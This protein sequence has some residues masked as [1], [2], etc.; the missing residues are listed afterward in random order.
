ML[1]L[2]ELV[3]F[4]TY[5]ELGTL[6]KAAESLH[7]SQPT[8]TRTMQ[9]V[10]ESF[11]VTLFSRSKNKIEL[12]QT[13]EKALALCRRLLQEADNTV[14]QVRLY[15]KSLRTITVESCA[16]APLWSLL[17]SLSAANPGLT[18]T[19]ELK[20]FD[21]ILQHLTEGACDLG[22]VTSDTAVPEHFV[23]MPFLRESLSVCV[24]YDHQLAFYDSL[25]F[26]EMN[27][28]NFLLY[29]EIGFWDG[30]CREKMP[31]SKFL[32]QTDA[33]TFQELI[34]QSKLPCFCTNLSSDGEF[35]T[36]RKIIPITDPQANITY[37]MVFREGDKEFSIPVQKFP[38]N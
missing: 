17:P 1:N 4:V 15:D 22:I 7:I 38:M 3:Q 23:S 20:G 19:S 9:R 32:V 5:G 35:L 2:E 6:T 21:A 8:I 36:D 27:G 10:E 24:P 29:S 31:A 37:H 30:M 34:R 18:I 13:G 33:F 28:Y 16:P 26:E 14:Q 11:G 12:N 25:T